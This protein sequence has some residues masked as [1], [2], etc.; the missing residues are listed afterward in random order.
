M[1]IKTRSFSGK[2]ILV[3]NCLLFLTQSIFPSFAFAQ[4]RLVAELPTPGMMVN[5]SPGYTSPIL[6]G[7]TLNTRDPLRFNFIID[8][9]DSQ[10]PEEE[11][12][13][14][15]KK[16]I[17]YFLSAL[18]IPEE[19]LWVNLSP[20]END[21]II[22]EEF[23]STE[24]GR[25]LL[26]QDYLLKQI[27]AS[28]VFPE[29]ELGKNFWEQVYR[30]AYAEFG[31]TQI[32]VNTFNKIWIVPE[33]AVVFEKDSTA[34]ILD[35]YLKVMLEED[36]LAMFSL[37]NQERDQK[38]LLNEEL[39]DKRVN[40]M[41]SQII[42]DAVLP[43]IEKEVNMG[44]NFSQLRQVFSAVILAA[45][46]KRNLKETLLSKIYVDQNKIA[47]I[48]LKDKKI[49]EKIYDQYMRAFKK[50]VY[51][52]IKED[53]DPV[54]QEMVPRKYFSGG[55]YL[56]VSGFQNQEEILVTYGDV[57]E[58]SRDMRM[59]MT[60]FR[61]RMQ[62]PSKVIGV[63]VALLEASSEVLSVTEEEDQKLINLFV[64]SETKRF[65]S[66]HLKKDAAMLT[67]SPKEKRIAEDFMTNFFYKILKKRFI[68]GE[69]VKLKRLKTK[70][71]EV[72]KRLGLDTRELFLRRP[73]LK[74]FLENEEMD[75]PA[76][77][78]ILETL[79][80]EIL[81]PLGYVAVLGQVATG[82]YA[83]AFG[84]IQ[85][86]EIIEFSAPDKKTLQV[87]GYLVTPILKDTTFSAMNTPDRLLVF[88]EGIDKN[89]HQMMS[90]EREIQK[91]KEEVGE[92]SLETLEKHLLLEASTL[93]MEYLTYFKAIHPYFANPEKIRELR[94]HLLKEKYTH[95]A[96]HWFTTKLSGNPLDL[97][98]VMETQGSHIVIDF[99]REEEA[100]VERQ[101][102]ALTRNANALLR[103]EGQLRQRLDQMKDPRGMGK[104]LSMAEEVMVELSNLLQ[105]NL[106]WHL[107][108][109]NFQS[110]VLKGEPLKADEVYWDSEIFMLSDF[111]ERLRTNGR[112]DYKNSNKEETY[113]YLLQNPEEGRKW[114][115]DL[116]KR[117]FTETALTGLFIERKAGSLLIPRIVDKAML[118]TTKGLTQG[119]LST[120]ANVLIDE[121]IFQDERLATLMADTIE[122]KNQ[123]GKNTVFIL[124]SG[125][126]PLEVYKKF[127]TIVKARDL[128]LSRLVTFNMDEYYVGPDYKKLT[129][130]SWGENPQSYRYYMENHLFRHLYEFGFRK[131]NI[132][133]LNG[134]AQDSLAEA[135]RYEEKLWQEKTKAG[136][137]LDIGYGG[138][139]SDGHIAF[140]EPVI[141]VDDK[142]M[143][144]N[145]LDLI[146]KIGDFNEFLIP[147]KKDKERLKTLMM[148]I[149][150]IHKQ[151]RLGEEFV[152]N[153]LKKINPK[154]SEAKKREFSLEEVTSI[155]EILS[156][157]KVTIYIKGLG[158]RP[159][160]KEELDSFITGFKK[161]SHLPFAVDL[162]DADSILDSRTRPVEIAVSTVI[163]NSIHFDNPKEIT[164]KALTIGIGTFQESELAVIGAFGTG[165]A[166]AIDRALQG[167][168]SVEI[169]ASVVAR[170][171]KHLFLLNRESAT[172]I[173]LKK[174]DARNVFNPFSLTEQEF[175]AGTSL[176]ESNKP[177]SGILL[178]KESLAKESGIRWQ[179]LFF[180]KKILILDES[181]DQTADIYVGNL[182]EALGKAIQKNT[183]KRINVADID[184][185]RLKETIDFQADIVIAPDR[186]PQIRMLLKTLAE[187]HPSLGVNALFYT[188]L[189]RE[190]IKTAGIEVTERQNLS[191]GSKEE[192]LEIGLKALRQ[193]ASQLDR[194][195]YDQIL[196]F[197]S[198]FAASAAK[199]LGIGGE[200]PFANNF[201]VAEMGASGQLE[202][203]EKPYGILYG[204]E[205]KEYQGKEP[206]IRLPQNS[207]V[208]LASPHSDDPEIAL[209][210]LYYEMLKN[211]VYVHNVISDASGR[212][213][214]D[215]FPLFQEKL[216]ERQ[217]EY[218]PASE[219]R[220]KEIALEIKDEIRIQESLRAT[221]VYEQSAEV[222]RKTF[223]TNLGIV[224]GKNK[225]LSEEE[226][227]RMIRDHYS[228]ILNLH[229]QDMQ[230]LDI[231]V[232]VALAHPNDAHP[233]HRDYTRRSINA[234]RELLKD[235][236]FQNLKIQFLFYQAPWA[237]DY[238]TYFHFPEDALTN[239][240]E[241][242][243]EIFAAMKI[244]KQLI[245]LVTGELTAARF[246]LKSPPLE[247]MG[248]AYAER[249]RRER[250]DA[251]ILTTKE[252]PIRRPPILQES[253][254]KD[255]AMITKNVGGIDLTMEKLNLQIKRDTQGIPLP[256][257][258]Q[259]LES[260][261][262]DGFVPI[263]INITPVNN[264]P[265]ISIL[266]E[267]PEGPETSKLKDLPAG[268]AGISSKTF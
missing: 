131:E 71:E 41:T 264:I 200:F 150:F 237:G 260:I 184:P 153:L 65:P 137:V 120:G 189:E 119:R 105:S 81:I 251:A 83:L 96:N 138:I 123:K 180:D 248:G 172:N 219:E 156:Q 23:G 95:E 84:K 191:V 46:F 247:A 195:A 193:H 175:F 268:E 249:L 13:I 222:G 25:D 37:K 42:R 2:F 64:P 188:P 178:S 40:Q 242:S 202:V 212:A 267:I 205:A 223:V 133:F 130:Q 4:P 229:I 225:N 192:I 14:E 235:S 181:Q 258:L 167:P 47:G 214:L 76:A 261:K 154:R 139:G 174:L 187:H 29:N 257:N 26:A 170:F 53:F 185:L 9:G 19:N 196:V 20:Y 177:K 231:P 216:K 254:K 3:V 204:K 45:W 183:L 54:S 233:A 213:V 266:E 59:G 243:Q 111:M 28:V 259:P 80:R 52:Y 203:T 108:L 117:E 7:I 110:H 160:L 112:E 158:R 127:I 255:E 162:A 124:P 152:Q 220:K 97:L 165:K 118:T 240:P 176:E 201:V 66:P 69:E 115:E 140:N 43:T 151:S 109:G 22:P 210:L 163:D 173:D 75:F 146:N 218:D 238:N 209:P 90:F 94:D 106:Y 77:Y 60:D 182:I 142:D 39:H 87:S 245:A 149:L 141:F 263:I 244:K 157:Q 122:I 194:T 86:S 18:T 116:L 159:Q 227:I 11:L 104:V 147:L 132:N 136:G 38:E 169:A 85:N 113:R 8:I 265:F 33:R 17:K 143:M 1:R 99:T 27:A 61:A 12:K 62:D 198:Q 236:R 48:D 129:G 253:T 161:T 103:E 72:S 239:V 125:S 135:K 232:V 126:T 91:V 128:D 10:L 226:K 55:A 101:K 241:R 190:F 208:I 211:G 89:V 230:G 30:K 88:E 73:L 58:V 24:M 234:L 51:N 145:K 16:L 256:M 246:G 15:A 102:E 44:K 36:Y 186:N 250:I 224:Y 134:E 217:G 34:F 148:R 68:E 199:I 155:A 168:L 63:D 107:I 171:K 21:R 262:I 197:L 50:G 32:P 228:Q 215:T 179:R 6:K 121:K 31:T 206:L 207:H 92:L 5:L 67:H 164:G 56:N 114:A 82:G 57:K 144:R 79:N 93:R 78:Y 252:E 70:F 35:S 100:E 49:K 74:Q 166:K 98:E 221:R